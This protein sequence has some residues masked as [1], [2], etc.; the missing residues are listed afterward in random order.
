[1]CVM[2]I[3][4]KNLEKENARKASA[5]VLGEQR[6]ADDSK[7]CDYFLFLFF[8]YYQLVLTIKTC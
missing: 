3:V 2:K 5:A 8:Y 4:I 6:S 7:V 1:M